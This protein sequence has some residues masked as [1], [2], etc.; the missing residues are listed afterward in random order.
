VKVVAGPAVVDNGVVSRVVELPNGSGRV[1]TW[2]S[3]KG[4][5]P[6]GSSLDEF[7]QSKPV[8]SE[9][10]ARLGIPASELT[11]D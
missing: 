9:L 11:S 8:T 4:W 7:F 6:G 10:A 1:E 3:G 2:R 5:T